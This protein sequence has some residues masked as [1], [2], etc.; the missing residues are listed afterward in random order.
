VFDQLRPDHP[1]RP[2]DSRAQL[3]DSPWLS[4]HK[5]DLRSGQDRA[6]PAASVEQGVG[7]AGGKFL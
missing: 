2:L 6:E 7:I 5:P 3:A 1:Y 4:P